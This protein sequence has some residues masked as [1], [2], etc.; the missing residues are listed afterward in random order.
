MKLFLDRSFR[1][2]RI[3]SNSELRK[4]APVMR[5]DVINVSGWKDLDKQGGRYKDYFINA[6]RYFISNYSGFRGVQGSKAEINID[7][8]ASLP[9]DLVNKFD[10][11]FNH[12]TLE[13]ILDVNLALKNLCLLSKDIV[14]VVVPVAQEQHE[15]ESWGDYWRF[16][17]LSLRSLFT[18]FGLSV[19]YESVS[20]YRNAGVYLF[21]IASYHP[22]KWRRV[23]PSSEKISNAAENIGRTR[24]LDSVRILK[25][26][27]NKLFR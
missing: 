26:I 25:S 13:H 19:V 17:P 16:M 5:G 4:I 7:L 8:T 23:L 22:E 2:P 1:L 12:T 9:D 18:A 6:D 27:Y 15:S 24:L 11:V 14:I 3:W 21:M 10:V 20:K